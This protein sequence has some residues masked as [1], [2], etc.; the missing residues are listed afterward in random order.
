MEAPVNCLTGLRSPPAVTVTDQA[1]WRRDP[2]S[3]LDISLV[4]VF[5]G[6]LALDRIEGFCPVRGLGRFVPVG[7]LRWLRALVV[8]DRFRGVRVLGD[9]GVVELVV[10]VLPVQGARDGFRPLTRHFCDP[11]GNRLYVAEPS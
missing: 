2:I 3:C 7:R 9:V 5:R 8:R 1:V 11:D 6:F 4:V 10:D